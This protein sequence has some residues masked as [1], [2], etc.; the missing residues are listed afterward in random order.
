MLTTVPKTLA[1]TFMRWPPTGFV[2]IDATATLPNGTVF[3]WSA[4]ML[5][6]INPDAENLWQPAIEFADMDAACDFGS[7]TDVFLFVGPQFWTFN[8]KTVLLSGE[9]FLFFHRSSFR[10]CL[11]CR[12]LTAAA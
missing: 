4:G 6:A 8:M 5:Q 3:V 2:S 1:L 7:A 11:P 9:W 10:I 12:L